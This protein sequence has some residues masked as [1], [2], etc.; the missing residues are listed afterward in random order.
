M[1][2]QERLKELLNYNQE[3]GEFTWRDSVNSRA[4]SGSIAGTTTANGYRTI[5]IGGKKYASHRLA[6]VYMYGGTPINQIDHINHN[7]CDNRICNLR[8]VTASQNSK[9]RENMTNKSGIMNVYWN[10]KRGS[11]S[12]RMT[13]NGVLHIFGAY[14]DIELAELVASEARTSHGFHPNHGAYLQ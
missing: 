13:S 8:D 3:S 10:D 1:I 7:R 11:Y 12:V 14:K 2:T 4:K 5:G 6:W 9:N